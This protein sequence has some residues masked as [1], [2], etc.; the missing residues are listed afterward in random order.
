MDSLERLLR[1]Y[2]F[3]GVDLA[4]QCGYEKKIPQESNIFKTI[5]KHIKNTFFRDHSDEEAEFNRQ[6]FV[7]LVQE[8]QKK[9]KPRHG[10]VTLTVLPRVNLTGTSIDLFFIFK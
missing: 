2:N 9:L 3:D 1:D 10:D 5:W 6:G 7:A 8:L 4:W